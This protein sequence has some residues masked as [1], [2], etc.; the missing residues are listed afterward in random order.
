VVIPIRN[1]ITLVDETNRIKVVEA[2]FKLAELL[3]QLFLRILG[4][5]YKLVEFRFRDQGPE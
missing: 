2:Y 1:Q 5:D 3:A 4:Y